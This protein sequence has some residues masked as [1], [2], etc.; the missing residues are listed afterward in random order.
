M[1]NVLALF[2][3]QLMN[4]CAHSAIFTTSLHI[5]LKILQSFHF[6]NLI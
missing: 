3:N 2:L 6:I 1:G 5:M 4:V